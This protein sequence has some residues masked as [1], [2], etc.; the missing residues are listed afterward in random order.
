MKIDVLLFSYRQAPTSAL[1]AITACYNYTREAGHDVRLRLYGNALI[2]RARNVALATAFPTAT[3][4]EHGHVSSDADFALFLDDDMLPEPDALVR[5]VERDVPVVSALCTTKEPPVT[6]AAKAYDAESDQF[7]PL[8]RV[9][10]KRMV[11]GQFGVGAAFLLLRRDAIEALAEYYLSAR[12]WLEENRRML[13][14]LHV[15]SEFREAERQHKE[16][17][18]RANWEREKFLRVFDYAIAENEMQ[19][20]EDVTLSKRLIRLKIPISID[21]TVVVGHRGEYP[22]SAWDVM[23]RDQEELVAA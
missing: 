22:Y 11:T 10:I 6:I 9:N 17:I 4:D 19:L 16:A 7:V 1:Q 15:R 18:R 3:V 23:E 5:L 12:D 8:D 2:H 20:G 13:D 14:R 21:G